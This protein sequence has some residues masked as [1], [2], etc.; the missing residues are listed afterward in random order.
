[1][2]NY[3]AYSTARTV[4][5]I[6]TGVTPNEITLS[7]GAITAPSGAIL[8]KDGLHVP[9]GVLDQSPNTNPYINGT[10]VPRDV[11]VSVH[12]CAMLRVG[13]LTGYHAVQERGLKAAP[14][15]DPTGAEAIPQHCGFIVID[16]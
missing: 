2:Y 14:Y 16:N 13:G 8:V 10:A 1:M 7:G 12:C 6:N 9:F 15:T 3:G 5:A 11:E 4:S